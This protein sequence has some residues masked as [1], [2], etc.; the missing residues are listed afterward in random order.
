MSMQAF[1]IYG[2]QGRRLGYQ[3]AEAYGRAA[4][5]SSDPL[6]MTFEGGSVG[7]RSAVMN[8]VTGIR[9]FGTV[10]VIFYYLYLHGGL[11]SISVRPWRPCTDYL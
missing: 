8:A 1:G 10:I 3:S 4:R 5:H 11:Q 2:Q 7:Y 6:G 9:R